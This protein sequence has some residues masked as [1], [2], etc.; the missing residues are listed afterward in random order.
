MPLMALTMITKS[1]YL[2]CANPC[3]ANPDTG[4]DSSEL[5]CICKD[6]QFI[7]AVCNCICS[8]C[9]LDLICNVCSVQLCSGIFPIKKV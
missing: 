9:D 4:C 3:L 6:E 2:D 7:N 8:S 1:Q 5:K